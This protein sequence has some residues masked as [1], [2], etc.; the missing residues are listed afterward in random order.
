M[1]I[2]HTIE[3]HFGKPIVKLDADNVDEIEKIGT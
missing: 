3:K 1:H 2:C